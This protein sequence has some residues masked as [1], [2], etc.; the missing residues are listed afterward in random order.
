MD[1]W[2]QGAGKNDLSYAEGGGCR[3]L[4]CV[5]LILHC[6]QPWWQNKQGV[7]LAWECI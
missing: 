5:G 7:W 3:K 2:V 1:I 6:S 4:Q